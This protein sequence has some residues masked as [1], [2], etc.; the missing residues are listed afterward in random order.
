[1]TFTPGTFWAHPRIVLRRERVCELSS[2]FLHA[3]LWSSDRVT[4]L[5]LGSDGL[6]KLIRLTLP[7]SCMSFLRLKP[8]NIGEQR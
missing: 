8:E 5:L 1:M 4:E 2:I 6:K 7:Q 3:C